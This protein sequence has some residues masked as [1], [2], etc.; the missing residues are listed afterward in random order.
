MKDTEIKNIVG[1]MTLEDKVALTEGKNFWQTI[2]F[3]Q[4]GIPPLFMCDGP[5]GLRKQDT[6]EG[7]DILGVHKSNPATCFPPAVTTAASWDTDLLG[8]IGRAI[9]EEARDQG[10]GLVLG[11]GANL[12]RNPLCGRN[13]EYF[14]EDPY[15][16]G[17]LAAAYIRGLEGEGV[18]ACLKHFAANS[19]EHSRLSSDSIMDE[20]TLRELYLTAFEIAV[21]ESE[22]SVVMCAYSK[23]NGVHCS[24]HRGLLT[25]ILRDEWGFDGFVVS[26][27]GAMYDRVAAIH[28]GC[29]LNMPGG[30]RYMEKEVLAALRD[31]ALPAEDIDQCAER[32]LKLVF[33][34]AGTLKEKYTCDYDAHHELAKS[35]AE[36]GA[37]LL[38]NDDGV[39]PIRQGQSVALIGTPAQQMRYQGA[40]SSHINARRLS[41]PI[42]YIKHD[43]Y[44]PGDDENGETS[45]A[46]IAEAVA[47]AQSCEIAVIFSGLPD[48][49]ESEGFDR[50][51]MRMPEGRVRLIEA[52]ARANPNTVVVFF[53]GSAVECPWAD[54]VKAILYMGLPGQ[55]G[56]EA[57]ADL[58][59]GRANPCGKLAESWITRYEDCP[60][61]PY[62]AKT[63]DALYLEGLYVGYRYYDRADKDVRWPFGHGLSYTTFAFSDLRVE[64][65]R[66]T[67][68]VTNTGDR[69]GAEVVQLYTEA[70][71]DGVHRPLRE[72]KGFCKLSLLPGESKTAEFTLSDRSF[73]IWQDGWLVPAGDYAVCV[74]SGSRDLPLR[75]VIH[76]DGDAVPVPDWQAGSFYERCEG[77]PAQDEFERMLGRRYTPVIPKKGEFTKDNTVQEMRDHS[78]V[79]KLVYKYLE[80][81]MVKAFGRKDYNDPEFRMMMVACVGSPLRALQISGSVRGGIVPG[82][83][84]MANGRFL[85]GIR[86]MLK[87]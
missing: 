30:S 54:D 79:M 56:G 6:Q 35:A 64:N 61:A 2:A 84:E 63:K 62:Y 87:G 69:A 66:V 76:I 22:P 29:D 1:R 17:K 19:Q 23:L 24:D 34:A 57:A 3:E 21:K 46:L 49:Y 20:R 4:Y 38:K 78:L 32:I 27:W 55:A 9:G 31:G 52:V 5:H 72:L 10:A 50:E 45:D 44:A 15:L 75:A 77:S 39:L 14:S 58:L 82:L 47:A 18:G 51:N 74:G 16:A 86:R 26:D 42:D 37:V 7:A 41:R 83:L 73:A 60:S 12:K 65:N 33:R 71:Q 53:S 8:E 85:K 68:T 81:M 48:S 36:Q 80:R 13:F 28:A 25:D 67:C 59:Y 43:V 11:P 70:P 40:G